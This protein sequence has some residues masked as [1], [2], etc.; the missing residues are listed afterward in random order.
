MHLSTSTPLSVRTL[1]PGADYLIYHNTEYYWNW[2]P[3]QDVIRYRA[4]KFFIFKSLFYSIIKIVISFWVYIVFYKIGHIFKLLVWV[5]YRFFFFRYLGLKSK[6][7]YKDFWV[8]SYEN[9]SCNLVL[10]Q[11]KFLI[12][13]NW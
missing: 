10:K 9:F 1:A 3:V 5:P 11:S 7:K 2:K 12:C 6:Y 8:S 4:S 13:S